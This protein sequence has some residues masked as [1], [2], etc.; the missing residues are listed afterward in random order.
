MKNGGKETSPEL[1][2]FK[3]D[4]SP[5]NSPQGPSFD[6]MNQ[7]N[8]FLGEND[9]F[10]KKDDDGEEGFMKLENVQEQDHHNSQAQ[11]NENMIDDM[12]LY[13]ND[14]NILYDHH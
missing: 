6:R 8:K 9:E 2:N 3:D 10:L 13:D 7:L 1:L 14:L 5:S 12:V 4:Q 11:G